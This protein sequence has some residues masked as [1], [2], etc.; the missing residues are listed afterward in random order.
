MRKLYLL[1]SGLLAFG[2][3]TTVWAAN[4]NFT[5]D[6]FSGS[7]N[8]A[9]CHNG[10]SDSQG[11]DVSIEQHW[12]GSMMANATRDPLWRAKVATEI[13]RN[14]HLTD[15]LNDKCTA[16]HAPM[17]NYEAKQDGAT[18]NILGAGGLLDPAN[19]YHD[20]AMEG[21]SCT[22]C[23]QITD[24]PTLGTLAG[25]S[26]HYNISESKVAYGQYTDPAINPMLNNTGYT[27]T[28]G[29]HMG[30]SK[31]CA[32]CHDLK[33]PF[34]DADGN[35]VSTTPETEFPEQM[36]YTEWE[37]SDYSQGAGKQSCADCHMSRI[38]NVKI[39]NRPRRLAPRDNFA[40]HHM[41]GA[42]TVMMN[43]LKENQAELEV[44]ST[45]LDTSIANARAM[46]Q[47]SAILEVTSASAQGGVL[48]V[49]VRVVNVSGHKLPTSY[50]SR[51]AHLHFT[52][53]D[54]QGGVVFESGKLNA[55]GSIVGANGDV[56]PYTFEPHYDVITSA[57][58]VQIY[59]PIMGNTD[60]GV[61]YTLLRGAQYLKDNRLTPAGFDK[62]SVPN[63]IA[64]FGAALTDA[65][66]NSGEDTVTYQVPV[67]N[68]NY[69]VEVEF[70]YQTMQ[71]GFLLDLFADDD[72]PE[73]ADFKR[74]Y[75]NAAF[76]AE[77]I[78]ST[79]TNV[80]VN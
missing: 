39:S 40:Q 42:N 54:D 71:Y 69:T 61:T 79:S 63:D 31:V 75:E 56:D 73:V 53:R 55:D 66:F 21:V 68:G 45:N 44:T 9:F 17:A 22:L 32:T 29:A 48:S 65:D 18:F 76:N 19:P 47:T 51:R 52:V 37:F 62:N 34:V 6:H 49:D 60:G 1:L 78:T 24:D 20:E 57:D 12:S 70:I 77:V 4:A 15:V 25:S 80:S 64:V 2:A 74:M 8:C 50:P 27:P 38:D 30:E 67:S 28:Y 33:T 13:K 43:I 41:V 59:E 16:C 58:Q 35:L 46:L 72:Q 7:Q 10:L 26:G 5:S 14:P 11:N 23:H 36:V 3:S